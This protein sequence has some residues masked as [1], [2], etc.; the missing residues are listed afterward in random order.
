VQIFASPELALAD[1]VAKEARRRLGVDYVI[2]YEEG[3]YKVRL[4]AFASE[5][6]AQ[7]LRE[8]AIHGGFPGAF[9]VRA[10]AEATDGRN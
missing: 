4:G 7:V 8:K 3:L 10:T 6:G 2:Q 1:G 5:A 9:R